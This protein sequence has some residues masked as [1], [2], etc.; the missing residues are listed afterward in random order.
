MMR[1]WIV[2]SWLGI[3]M[4]LAGCQGIVAHDGQV[5]ADTPSVP[6][7][8]NQGYALLQIVLSKE[9]QVDKILFLK[10]PSEPIAL[11]LKDIAKLTQDAKQKVDE[12]AKEAGMD[13]E[14]NGM[15]KTEVM[16][17]DA[18]GS[19]TTKRVLFST[20]KNFEF[21]ILLAQHQAMDYIS[22][23]A[24]TL[25]DQDTNEARKKY[26]AQLADDAKALH[27]RVIKIMQDAYVN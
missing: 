8:I 26:M 18:I 4:G 15:P 22:H 11:V 6:V 1:Q 9:S 24:T 2:I 23:M 25:A 7:T 5:N 27:Q 10:G 20:D 21:Q 19:T 16:T 13:L 14:A 12:F 17:R 3:V